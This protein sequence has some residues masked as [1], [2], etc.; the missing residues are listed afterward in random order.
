MCGIRGPFGS[1]KSTTAIIKLITNMQ[2][3]KRGPDGV[4]RRRTAIIRN[5]YGELSTTTAK[6][7]NEW[8]PREVGRWVDKAPPTHTISTPDLE[9]EILFVALDRPEDLKKLL[10]MDLSDA[11]VNEAR[12]I[13]K[14]IIDGL[15]GRVGRYPATRRDAS[16]AILHT[17]AAPQIIMDTNPPDT[18]HWWAKMADFP[19]METRARNLELTDQLRTLGSLGPNQRLSEFF[20][21][22]SGRSPQAENL[23]NLIPGYYERLM[24]DKSPDWIKV[25]VDGEYG[26]VQ[27]GKPVY[28]EYVDSTHCQPFDL[29]R[30]MPVYVGIDFGLTPAATFG[31]RTPMGAWRI[32]S[33]LVTENM[34][35][36]QF[37]EILKREMNSR[38]QGFQFEA[39]TGD[40]A[41]E[42]RS[43]ADERTPFN[44]LL[45]SGVQARPAPTNDPIK[46]RETFAWFLSR[47]IDGKPGMLIHPNCQKLRKALAGG[48]HY[49]RVQSAVG[50]EI[51]TP[52]PV[53]DMNSH[54]AEAGQ[55]MLLGAGE[56]RT[57]MRA[58]PEFRRNRPDFAEMQFNPFGDH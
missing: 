52:E 42:Q 36:L 1:A 30:G 4:A 13:P 46:R 26:F 55:Y 58:A 40:P 34:G 38:Y 44:A 51:Y 25:Y 8:I 6:T 12:E 24:A 11:W 43:Q 53:K 29:M 2:K 50:T 45:A 35:A 56:A 39:I 7:W 31:Q 28:P 19:D 57:V 37:G 54:I 10:S 32:H 33:E 47:M 14:Q 20:A 41:G 16:G 5:T 9:W 48:Y 18:D 15:S 21:Q 17:C 23:R 27:E 49:R 22:P 3:Q